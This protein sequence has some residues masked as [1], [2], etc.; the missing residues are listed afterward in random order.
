MRRVWYSFFAIPNWSYWL[1]LAFGA[2]L[3]ACYLVA[4]TSAN[5]RQRST[6]FRDQPEVQ[7]QSQDRLMDNIRWPPV[8]VVKE[9]EYYWSEFLDGEAG[10][11][12]NL[13]DYSK[14]HN[15]SFF[16]EV[17]MDASFVE[18]DEGI[19]VHFRAQRRWPQS[20]V[21]TRIYVVARIRRLDAPGSAELC[22]THEIVLHP[23]RLA[24][25]VFRGRVEDLFP[26]E[27]TNPNCLRSALHAEG[28][29]ELD[30]DVSIGDLNGRLLKLPIRVGYLVY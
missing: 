9:G 6:A 24:P 19:T 14:L 16:L 23:S 7:A 21:L 5:D 2:V 8:T 27:P 22:S 1:F 29:Y 18:P 30:M 28:N 10:D 17:W 13:L 11:G 12:R 15:D 26:V 20:A 4:M 25:G 3:V